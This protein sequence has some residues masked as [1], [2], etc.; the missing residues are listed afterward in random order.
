[1]V[2]LFEIGGGWK[3]VNLKEFVKLKVLIENG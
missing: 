3:I 2:D 1:M